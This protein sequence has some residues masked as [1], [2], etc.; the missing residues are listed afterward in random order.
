MSNNADFAVGHRV[1]IYPGS[2]DERAGVIVEDFGDAGGHAVT[3]FNTRIA[4][5]A[6]RWAVSLDDGGLVFI[7]TID[8]RPV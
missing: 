3:V 8:M 1:R 2:T 4:E 7:D 5:A 6:R